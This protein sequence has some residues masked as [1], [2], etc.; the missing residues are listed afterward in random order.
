MKGCQAA[1]GGLPAPQKA[2]ELAPQLVNSASPLAKG[3]LFHPSGEAR[4]TT[5]LRFAI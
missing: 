4:F 2:L 5:L 3:T 1:T